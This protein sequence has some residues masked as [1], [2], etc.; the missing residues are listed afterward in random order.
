MNSRDYKIL[1]AVLSGI[2]MAASWIILKYDQG[3]LRD[4]SLNIVAETFGILITIFFIDILIKH[5]G[6]KRE[7]NHDKQV[8][9]KYIHEVIE[10]IDSIIDCSSLDENYIMQ[11]NKSLLIDYTKLQV[12]MRLC[13]P[14]MAESFGK[15]RFVEKG[16]NEQ[17][18]EDSS[19]ILNDLEDYIKKERI[20]VNKLK[21]IRG[22]LL[23]A[24]LNILKMKC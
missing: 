11:E 14:P 6:S 7:F 2:L 18:L 22:K 10:L 4:L 12:I 1:G 13:N 21:Q 20:D 24:G 15:K 9:F 17:S 19:Y 3:T 5:S 23:N 8:R 16:N